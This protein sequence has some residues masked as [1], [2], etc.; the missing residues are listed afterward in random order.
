MIE[1]LV[2]P[3]LFLVMKEPLPQQL[4]NEVRE[5]QGAA[6]RHDVESDAI[7]FDI[8]LPSVGQMQNQCNYSCV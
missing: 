2:C 8:A 4:L 6:G 5:E 7:K 3:Q 1:K